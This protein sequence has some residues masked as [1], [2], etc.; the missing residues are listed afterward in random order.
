[1]RDEGWKE[2]PAGK[3]LNLEE[4]QIVIIRRALSLR[5][6]STKRLPELFEKLPQQQ[7]EGEQDLRCIVNGAEIPER[8]GHDLVELQAEV[9]SLQKLV[10]GLPAGPSVVQWQ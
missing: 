10:R 9:K 3:E 8:S 5:G 6:V 1:M 2:D 7:K 4:F